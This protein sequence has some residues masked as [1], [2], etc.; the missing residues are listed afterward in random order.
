VDE[1][2]HGPAE[3]AAPLP[4]PIRPIAAIIFDLDGVLVD[5][6]IWWD[7]V[8]RGF[9]RRHGRPWTEADRAAVMGANSRQW[10]GTMARRLALDISPAA[11]E[12]AVV[13]AMVE[14]WRVGP[15][16]NIPGAPDAV[17]RLARRFPLALASSAHPAV[18]EAALSTTGLRGLFRVVVSSDE[19]AHGKPEPD[20]YLEAARRLGVPAGACLVI[21]DSLNGVLA[22]RAAGMTVILV[23]N[24][25]IP[26]AAGAAEAADA[27]V[28]DLASLDPMALPRSR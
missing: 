28:P 6:E 20:V 4:E 3:P 25:S 18:I 13:D 22:A 26:P 21:E 27:V 16:P 12:R 10:S 17:R 2:R 14:R 5:T 23:P 8:R 11:I 15:E 1:A 7:E 19:V 24:Q 9:A